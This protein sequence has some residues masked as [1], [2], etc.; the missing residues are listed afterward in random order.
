MKDKAFAASVNRDNIRECEKIGLEL[1]AFL[2]LVIAAMKA[3][4]DAAQPGA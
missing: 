2:T 3:E 1:D 4:H